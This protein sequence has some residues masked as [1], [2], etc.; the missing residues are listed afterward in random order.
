MI[1]LEAIRA[2]NEAAKERFL[3]AVEMDLTRGSNVAVLLAS[4]SFVDIDALLAEVERL[5][6][7]IGSTDEGSLL[8]AIAQAT[9]ATEAIALER[10]LLRRRLEM[11]HE[12][13]R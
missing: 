9:S 8:R 7:V 5:R 6:T 13:M 4:T 1:D 12:E 2:R 10:E 11:D 3:D